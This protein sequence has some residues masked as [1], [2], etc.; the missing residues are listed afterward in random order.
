MCQSLHGIRNVGRNLFE[1][2]EIELGVTDDRRR[3][4]IIR[5]L[6]QLSREYFHR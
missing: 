3:I 1:L 2:F 6:C 4:L 5:R